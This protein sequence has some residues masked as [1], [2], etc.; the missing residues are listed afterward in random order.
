MHGRSDPHC[1]RLLTRQ[2]NNEM[3]EIVD[4]FEKI[5]GK[6]VVLNTSFNLHGFPIARDAREA[7]YIFHNSGLEFMQLGPF[8]VSKK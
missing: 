2:Q 3:Y 1:E 7:M 6:G 5:T 4:Q 8:L